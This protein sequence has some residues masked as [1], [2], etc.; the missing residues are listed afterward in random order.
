MSHVTSEEVPAQEKPAPTIISADAMARMRTCWE[1]A[2]LR[3]QHKSFREIAQ[4]LGFADAADARNAVQRWLE[5]VPVEAGPDLKG[6]EVMRQQA[7]KRF[8]EITASLTAIVNDPGP[9][10]SAGKIVVNEA[11]G[12]PYPDSGVRVAAIRLLL[13]VISR[14][15]R[16]AG[17]H[18]PARPGSSLLDIPL[19]DLVRQVD[20]LKAELGWPGDGSGKRPDE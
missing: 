17:L 19:P 2:R 9:L 1:A 18:A 12:E 14:Q 10:V 20:E 13:L 11:T 6:D 15:A 5:I 4:E 8:G 3:A 7:W 16:L